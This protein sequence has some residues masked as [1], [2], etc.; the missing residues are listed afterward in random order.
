VRFD[1][2]ADDHDR[3]GGE[4]QGYEVQDPQLGGR[5]RLMIRLIHHIHGPPATPHREVPT[6]PTGNQHPHGEEWKQRQVVHR[7][8]SRE[9]IGVP[10]FEAV[11]KGEEVE[12]SPRIR[13]G[14]GP[15]QLPGL[16]PQ[17]PGEL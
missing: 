4:R 13:A 7:I 8:G 12:A 11:P 9:K 10:D 17:H 14:E 5:R 1:E 2:V 15:G 6:E 3:Q 16:I